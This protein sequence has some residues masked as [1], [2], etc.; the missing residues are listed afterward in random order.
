MPT[1]GPPMPFREY[2][3]NRHGWAESYSSDQPL[4]YVFALPELANIVFLAVERIIRLEFGVRLPTAAAELAKR[5]WDSLQTL[6]RTLSAKGYYKDAP[7]DLRP[8]PE[9][10]NRADVISII[11]RFETKLAAY[12]SPQTDGASSK[13]TLSQKIL[14][15]L[16]QFDTDD[17]IDC[18]LN[19]LENFR[20][21]NREDT[22]SCVR[23]F[24]AQHPRF[25]G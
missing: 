19:I 21:L 3:V 14:G 23:A 8:F 13:A 4:G 17:H 20:M 9:R 16:K 15:W 1:S 10:L 12:Q 7:Y 6:K 25:S 24:I 2:T 22:V 5:D 11:A 18:A